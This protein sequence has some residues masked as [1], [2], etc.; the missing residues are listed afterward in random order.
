MVDQERSG[1][2]WSTKKL[3]PDADLPEEIVQN[4]EKTS[5]APAP[6]AYHRIL[7]GRRNNMRDV[8]DLGRVLDVSSEA[9]CREFIQY[10]R[11]SLPLRHRLPEDLTILRSLLVELMTTLEIPV[12]AL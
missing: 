1:P 8:V 4:L 11:L 10:G 3:F 7:Q 6:P 2:L 5:T 12:L 9:I